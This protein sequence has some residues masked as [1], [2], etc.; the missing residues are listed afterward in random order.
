MKHSLQIS[1]QGIRG[2]KTATKNVG[3]GLLTLQTNGYNLCQISA[4]TFEG[5]GTDYKERENIEIEIYFT[6]MAGR[7]RGTIAELKQKLFGV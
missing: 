5:S 7:W 2:G 4:D 3:W 1:T 6:G